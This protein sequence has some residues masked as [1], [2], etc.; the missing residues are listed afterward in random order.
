MNFS[1]L[2]G[3]G[4]NY[5]AQEKLAAAGAVLKMRTLREQL[6]DQIAYH[7]AK[8]ADLKAACD[9]LTPDVEKALDALQKL[10]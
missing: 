6:Q 1:N 9:A 3:T 5:P 2:V 10:S 4:S 7:E 8:I